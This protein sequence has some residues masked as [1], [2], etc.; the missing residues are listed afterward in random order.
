MPGFLKSGDSAEEYVDR[1]KDGRFNY[2]NLVMGEFGGPTPRLHVYDFFQNNLMN[3][4][5]G[6]H[7]FGNLPPNH[8]NSR[9]Q[10]GKEVFS[11]VL[12]TFSHKEFPDLS[13][14]NK[15]IIDELFLMLSNKT[16]L[17]VEEGLTGSF[18]HIFNEGY[19]VLNGKFESGSVSSTVFIVDKLNNCHFLERTN[20]DLDGKVATFNWTHE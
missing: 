17:P 14:R 16:E 19:P 15:Y 8:A 18:R 10:Y 3:L 7:C 6:V 9:A 13:T 20:F 1:I 5:P 4:P 2:F 11:A 12:E